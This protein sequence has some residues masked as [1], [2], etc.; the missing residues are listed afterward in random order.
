MDEPQI[1]GSVIRELLLWHAKRYGHEETL[2]LAEHVPPHLLATIDTR[3][4]AFGILGASWYPRS[5]THPMLDRVVERAGNEGREIAQAANRDVVPKMIRG[6]YRML[7]RTAASPELYARHVPRF[8]KRLH[9]TGA[10]TM[11]IRAPGE[12]FSTVDD[13][14]GHHPFLCWMTI[15]TM[16]YVFEAMGYRHWSVDRLACV[17]HGGP[18]CETRFRYGK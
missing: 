2:R 17:E 1:K 9:T 16:A 11:E 5:L 10:R 14:A 6:I 8:W 15:Y 12:A 18:R 4:P 3:Q 7:F 13:W